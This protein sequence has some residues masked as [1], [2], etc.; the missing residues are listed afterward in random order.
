MQKYFFIRG[1]R[2]RFERLAF[3]SIVYVEASKNYVNLVTDKGSLLVAS[4]MK[5][6]ADLLPWDQFCRIHKSYII[7][8]SRVTAFDKEKVWLQEL[9]LP[10]GE[11]HKA[12]FYE[13]IVVVGD[14]DREISF[15]SLDRE[16]VIGISGLY[17]YHEER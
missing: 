10:L 9:E 5:Q 1:S 14:R 4:T 11:A 13:R 16:G 8:L 15:L 6:I 12:G 7:A 2:R 3:D 17:N